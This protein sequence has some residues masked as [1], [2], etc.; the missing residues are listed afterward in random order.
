[1]S[2]KLAISL[3]IVVL[4]IVVLLF[5]MK[6]SGSKIDVNMI[7]FQLDSVYKSIVFLGFTLAGVLIGIFMK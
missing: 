1:M 6:G 5:N 4:T 2:K 3:V 7:V